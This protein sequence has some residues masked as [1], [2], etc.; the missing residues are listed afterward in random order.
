[1]IVAQKKDAL[2][3]D[4]ILLAEI[5]K[6]WGRSI[7]GAKRAER[8]LASPSPSEA[9][10]LRQHLALVDVARSLQPLKLDT[11]SDREIEVTSTFTIYHDDGGYVI[12]IMVATVVVVVG[13]RVLL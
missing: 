7:N 9:A 6:G 1:M 3:L 2:P 12:W 4:A 5:P 13:M 10:E 8:S 11:L